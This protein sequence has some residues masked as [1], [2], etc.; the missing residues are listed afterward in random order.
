LSF[1]TAF[2]GLFSAIAALGLADVVVRDILRNPDCAPEILG[3]ASFLQLIGGLIAYLFILVTIVFL[4]PNDAIARTI[5]AILGSITLLEASKVAVF[6]FESQMQSKYI[7]WVQNGV[8]LVFA[9]MKMVL[10]LQQASLIA[11]VWANLAEALLAA[12]ILLGVMSKRGLSLK[13][14]HV[15]TKRAKSLLNDSWPLTLSA[16]AIT[17]YMKID[18]IMLGQILDNKAVGTYAVA[19]RISEVWYLVIPIVIASVFPTLANLHANQSNLL[20]KRWVQ[21]YALMFWLSVGV[22]SVLTIFSGLIIN[23]LFG[24][25]YSDAKLA[26]CIHVWAGV[27]VAVGS[28]WSK[29]LL[30]ENKLK[31]GFYGHILGSILNIGLNFWFIPIYGVEGAALATLASYWLSNIFVLNLHKP[32]ET[33]SLIWRAVLLPLSFPRLIAFGGTKSKKEDWKNAK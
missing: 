31:L 1:A 12:V 26:L 25:A 24:E 16:I 6:W 3:T 23:I 8:F 19:V 27:N 30:L 5:V 13:L 9:A 32:H 11:F 17:L 33:F 20:P 14:L 4:R 2:V 28:V 10:I 15:S 22:A 29:W 18:Q 7:V 21:A